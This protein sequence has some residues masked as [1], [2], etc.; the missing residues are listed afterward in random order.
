MRHVVFVAPLMRDA[1]L[2]LVRAIARL[3][4]IVLSLISAHGPEHLPPD[5]EDQ[6]KSVA[7][8]GNAMDPGQVALAAKSLI[9]ENGPIDRL[10]GALEELQVPIAKV[11]DFLNIDGMRTQEAINFRE[12]AQMKTVFR[13]HGVPCAHHCLVTASPQAIEFA[14]RVGFPLVVKPPAGAGARNTFTVEN[15]DGLRD[16]MKVYQPSTA[17]PVLLEE[18]IQG[19]EYTFEAISIRGKLH[20]HSLCRYYPTPLE[21]LK[22]PWIKWCVLLPKE[23][24]DPKWNEIRKLNQQ[25]LQSLGMGTGLSHME[26]FRRRK[27]GSIAISEV[28]ARP[29]GAQIMTLMSYAHDKNFYHAW[30]ELM[31]FDRFEVPER[32]YAAGAAFLRGIGQGRVKAIHGIEKARQEVGS[33]VMEAKLPQIGQP[34]SPSYEG[35]GYVLVRHPDTEVVKQALRKLIS[36][37]QIEYA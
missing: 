30:A 29:P 22:N 1:T 26:W 3:D 5:L 15:M 37:I 24:D 16:Y 21:V 9:R 32:R 28:G 20:W 33:L 14:E 19:D 7:K 13:Q 27:D 23:L 34:S 8:V 2:R 17:N 12:K 35:E 18:F 10:F 4:G 36:T 31:V 25:A 6:V 11:R